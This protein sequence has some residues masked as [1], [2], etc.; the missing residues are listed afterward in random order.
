[1]KTAVATVAETAFISTKVFTQKTFKCWV[2]RRSMTDSNRYEP[3]E[4]R[5]VMSPPAGW[6]HA[7]IEANVIHFLRDFVE[8]HDLGKVF[9]SSAGYDLP[10][11]DTLEPDASFIHFPR[12]LDN[13]SAGA[14]RAIS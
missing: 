14:T 2:D 8:R 11:G 9:S 1:M 7:E 10:S 6:G 3:I 13:G 4:G 12:T 5:I